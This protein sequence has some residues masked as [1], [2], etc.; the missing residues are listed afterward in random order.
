MPYKIELPDGQVAQFPDNYPRD[1]AK[2]A[3]DKYMAK[4]YPE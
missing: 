1:K 2:L 4:L 3:V